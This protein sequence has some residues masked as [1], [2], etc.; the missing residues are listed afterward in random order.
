[1]TPRL[2]LRRLRRVAPLLVAIALLLP[3][4]LV[5][6]G[7]GAAPEV[8]IPPPA[9]PL[10]PPAA[11]P[12]PPGTTVRLLFIHHSCGGQLLADPGSDVGRQCIYQS[13]PNGGG[14]RRVLAQQGYEVHEASYGSVIGEHTDLRDWPP[15]FRDAM[16]R[17]LR[18]DHQDVLYP[19]GRRNQVVVFKPCFT[20]SA[21]AA[22]G[23]PPG[24]PRGR[25]HTLWNA[26]AAMTALL[27]ELRTRPDVLFVFVTAPPSAPRAPPEPAWRWLAETVLRRPHATER[28]KRSA[29]LAR[30]FNRWITAP[31][32]WLRDDPVKN[33]VVF[34]YFDLLTAGGRSDFLVY[35]S[36]TGT[37]AHP[38]RIGQERAAAAFAS[39][40]DRAVRRAGL[41]R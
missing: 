34:D 16:E 15:K 38:S 12:L 3:A 23:T 21:F 20:E 13:H 19:D 25:V 37:D 35:F 31:D 6:V 29:V 32:G 9:T 30:Q 8:P 11:P 5:P 33:V 7:G 2:K 1:M 14:L 40:L 17:V 28:W 4:L 22:E 10:D 36:G 26:R 27:G 18:T 41:V 24:N 39:F